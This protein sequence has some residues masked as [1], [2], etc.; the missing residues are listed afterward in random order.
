MTPAQAADETAPTALTFSPANAATN[1]ATTSTLGITFSEDV[2]KGS[3]NILVIDAANPASV[4]SIDVTSVGVAVN[5]AEVTIAANLE[6]GKQ[7]Y[8]EIPNTAFTDAAGNAYAGISGNT[9]WAFTTAAVATPSLAASIAALDFGVLPVNRASAAL[10]YT[11]SASDLSGDV[12]VTASQG[13]L[14]AKVGGEFGSTLTFTAAELA[15]AQTIKVQATPTAEGALAGTITHTSAGATDVLVNLNALAVNP[16]AQNFNNCAPVNSTTL[17]GGW[18][19][20]S[21]TGDQKWGCT[22]FGR[23]D[24]TTGLAT[25]AVQINGYSGGAKE[26]EDWLISPVLNLDNF[27]IPLLSFW[28]RVAF[29]GPGLKVMISENYDPAQAPATATWTE[30]NGDFPAEASDYWKKSELDL[31]AYKGKAVHVAFVYTSSATASAARWT[32][33]DFAVT[34]VDKY[35]IADDFNF[36]FGLVETPNASEAKTFGFTAAGLT[37]KLTLTATTGFE[38]S[39]DNGQ[40]FEQA[41]TYTSAEANATH[42]V[43]VRFRPATAALK[44]AGNVTFASG[45]DFNV[46]KGTLTGSS[47]SKAKT[48]DIVTWNVEWFGADKDEKGAEL[49]PNDEELQFANVKKAMQELDA[50]IFALEEVSNDAA[51]AKLVNELGNYDFVKSDVTSYSWDPTKNLTPQ[52][53]YFVYKKDVVKVKSQKVLLQKLYTDVRNGDATLANYPDVPSSFW[54]SGR[55]PFMVEVEATLNGT[56]QLLNLVAMHTRANSGTDETKYKQRK[57]DIEVLRDSLAAQYGNT[58]LVLLGDMN[59]DVDVSVVNSLT[60]SLDA[61]VS[62]ANFNTLTLDLSKAGGYTYASGSLKS[63]LDHIIISKSLEDEYIQESITIENALVNSIASYRTT[64]SDHA[65][66]SARFNLS[67]TPVV[68]FAEASVVK[69]EDA[70]TFNVNLTVS[71]AQP[72]AQTVTVTLGENTTDYTIAGAVNGVAAVTIPA[73]ATTAS[74]EVSITEDAIVEANEVVS[75]KLSAVNA[76]LIVG[77]Q[78]T[79]DLTITDNDKSTVNFATNALEAAE[80]TGEYEITV[81]LDQPTVAEQTVKVFVSSSF[82]TYATDY[83][84]DPVVADNKFSLTIPAGAAKA[85]FKVTILDDA[86][87]ELN[88]V[89]SFELTEPSAGIALGNGG[90]FNITI[91]DTDK[92]TVNFATSTATVKESAGKFTV[93]LAVTEAQTTDQ[94][95]AVTMAE[96]ATDYSVAGAVN[97]VLNV[98]IPAN[99]TTA[100]F[101]VTINNDELVELDETFSFTLTAADSKLTVGEQNTFAFVIEDN[102]KSAVNFAAASLKVTEDAGTKV[103]TITLDQPTVTQQEVKVKVTNGANVTAADY[104]AT[105]AASNGII[106]VSIPA[107]AN[108]ATFSVAILNDELQ[109]QEE[110]VTFELFEVSNK[111]TLGTSKTFSLVIDKNDMPTGIADATKGQFTL[112]PNPTRGNAVNLILPEHVATLPAINLSIWTADGRKVQDFTG[113][114]YEVQQQLN[115]RVTTLSNGMYLLKV[116]AGK[117]LYTTR[118]IKN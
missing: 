2:V 21:V 68:T 63:F 114:Q 50:D 84:T 70:G 17:S 89:V 22:T 82:A 10:S 9:A 86:D 27:N 59:D 99:A 112:Y 5:G 26:N 53:L 6:A 98:T 73:N 88:E 28:S 62:N 44:F 56:T 48:L 92:S 43:L 45:S 24:E 106:A 60:T 52:K 118:L 20:Y 110:T 116:E 111:L 41:I 39:K 57:Y 32:F 71:E 117:V 72:T 76:N 37:D 115:N 23:N 29:A 1:V 46:T 69:A 34:N 66:V 81:E 78:N 109:E 33:D 104:T 100:S 30:L 90:N 87:V 11:L 25:N 51:M 61:F 97:G 91:T 74:F 79:L 19:Q 101:D 3:G 42:T 49:G 113:S 16:F 77:T 107:G 15:T 93:N 4:Q 102:D 103:V 55:L 35:V 94:T 47:L 7:Y 13:Y 38:L 95:V 96:N 85:T 40:N 31:S 105:P 108:T 80:G 58:N 65:P 12:T 18:M 54:A 36:D 14:I 75:F 83:T 67:A 64:T 8:I